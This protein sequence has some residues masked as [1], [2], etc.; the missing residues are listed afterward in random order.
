MANSAA[1]LT[2]LQRTLDAAV[3]AHKAETG[4]GDHWHFTI[5]AVIYLVEWMAL[6][7]PGE[8]R[9]FLAALGERATALTREE[10]D[11]ADTEIIRTQSAL[12]V[13]LRERRAS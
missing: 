2:S 8:T 12:F 5:D 9:E 1:H 7:C 3:K 11:R 4:Q 13:T 10:L 6:A